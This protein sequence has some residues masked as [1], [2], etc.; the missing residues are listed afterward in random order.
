MAIKG[1]QT[2]TMLSLIV[3]TLTTSG[4]LASLAPPPDSQSG[5]NVPNDARLTQVRTAL[6]AMMRAQQAYYI[7]EGRFAESLADLS[8]GVSEEIGD[9]RL[10]IADMTAEKAIMTAKSRSPESTDLSAG[11]FAIAGS[12]PTTVSVLCEGETDPKNPPE[13]QLS[14]NQAVCSD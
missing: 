6:S 2:W 7:E 14:G 10:E 9:Y 12:P 5:A 8:I 11:V 13:P 1:W 4:C 3:G